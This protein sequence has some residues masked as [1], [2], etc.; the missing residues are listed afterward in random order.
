ME[1]ATV[2]AMRKI[3]ELENQKGTS[4]LQMMLDAGKSA[5]TIIAANYEVKDKQVV[6]L[7]GNGN[8]GGDGFVVAQGLLC[9]LYTSRCV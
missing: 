6:V 1:F 7:C 3:E 5:T 2:A 8:N 4:Y 9:L